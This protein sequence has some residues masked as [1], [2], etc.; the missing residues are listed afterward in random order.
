[1]TAARGI[2]AVLLMAAGCGSPPPAPES[3][4]GANTADVIARC[5]LFFAL[6]ADVVSEWTWDGHL[7]NRVFDSGFRRR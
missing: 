7:C 3:R 5:S 1:M 6:D 4:L 2:V